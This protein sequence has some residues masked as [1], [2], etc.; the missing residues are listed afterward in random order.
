MFEGY[1]DQYQQL[2]P[3]EK[4]YLFSHPQHASIIEDSKQKA[5]KETIRLFGHNGHNDKSDA[6]R[7]CF[8]S[9]LLSR[10]I[11]YHNA[12][13]SDP[14]NPKNEKNMDI[15]NNSI[16]IEI[17]RGGGSDFFLSTRCLTALQHGKLKTTP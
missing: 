7:H 1:Y 5:F 8:W 14:G 13:E 10:D 16:G 9:A 4:S 3:K 2:T 6:F 11:G 12:H 15:Y 17:G